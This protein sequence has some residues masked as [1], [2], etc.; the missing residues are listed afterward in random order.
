MAKI[1]GLERIE[2][3]DAGF[4]GILQSD[5]CKE[6]IEETTARICDEANANNTRGG[7]GFASEVILSGRA[8]RYIGLIRPTDKNA[9]TAATED[10]AVERALHE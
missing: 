3:I 6:L 2:F 1:S 8:G 7:D 9:V 4:K 5:G 10:S